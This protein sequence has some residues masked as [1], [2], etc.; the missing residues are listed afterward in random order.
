MSSFLPRPALAFVFNFGQLFFSIPPARRFSSS[1]RALSFPTC[2]RGLKA[3]LTPPHW[4][5]NPRTLP[6]AAS[7]SQQQSAAAS[8]SHQR[9]AAAVT[10]GDYC[11]IGWTK[12]T[13]RTTINTACCIRSYCFFIYVA[14]LC[15]HFGRVVAN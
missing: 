4:G 13:R 7:S 10:S 12:S 8:S 6:S 1:A 14:T 9:T 3:R 5:V 11:L 2:L 15:W